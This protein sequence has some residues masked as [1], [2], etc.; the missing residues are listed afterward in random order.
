MNLLSRNLIVLAMATL[1]LPGVTNAEDLTVQMN[2]VNSMR[3][4][5]RQ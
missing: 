4:V 2:E 3:V 1:A 5:S